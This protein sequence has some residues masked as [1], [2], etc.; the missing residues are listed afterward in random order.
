MDKSNTAQMLNFLASNEHIINS[1]KT[2]YIN[3]RIEIKT[4]KLQA[5]DPIIGHYAINKDW[6]LGKNGGLVWFNKQEM[7]IQNKVLSYLIKKM[8]SN[9]IHGK[10]VVNIS[11]PVTIFDTIS[12][13]ERL[14][15]SYTY[16]PYF[17]ENG[18]NSKRNL[19]S[20]LLIT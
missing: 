7:E 10:S 12:F 18:I 6:S 15:N 5:I 19:T 1:I 4:P 13:L 14:A 20:I 11:L 16:A 8:G 2:K 3:H 17:L 9:L